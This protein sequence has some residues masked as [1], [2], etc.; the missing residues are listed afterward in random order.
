MVSILS[1]GLSFI[2]Q[3]QLLILQYYRLKKWLSYVKALFP[4]QKT[5]INN[6]CNEFFKQNFWRWWSMQLFWHIFS[7]TSDGKLK[8]I[9]CCA[10]K[11]YCNYAIAYCKSVTVKSTTMSNIFKIALQKKFAKKTFVYMNFFFWII[12]KGL[13]NTNKLN[14]VCKCCEWKSLNGSCFSF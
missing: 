12:K 11:C 7:K 9:K 6:T 5:V 8:K 14:K 10:K 2:S 1:N 13:E 3:L 4:S